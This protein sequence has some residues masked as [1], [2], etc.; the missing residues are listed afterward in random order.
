MHMVADNFFRE[1]ITEF[2]ESMPKYDCPPSPLDLGV[3]LKSFEDSNILPVMLIYAKKDLPRSWMKFKGYT[4]DKVTCMKERFLDTLHA[5]MKYGEVL[6]ELIKLAAERVE[7]LHPGLGVHC[8]TMSLRFG[9]MTKV[10]NNIK[11]KCARQ[12]GT[13]LKTYISAGDKALDV[14]SSEQAMANEF[15][16]VQFVLKHAGKARVEALCRQVNSNAGPTVTLFFL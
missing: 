4:N 14:M 13:K 3:D 15:E 11:E 10:A 2:W 7:L 6:M 1:H 9:G 12:Y 5:K 8:M 16:F